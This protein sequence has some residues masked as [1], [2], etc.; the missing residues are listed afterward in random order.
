MS[1]PGTR[2][3]VLVMGMTGFGKS[4]WTKLY[5]QGFSRKVVY[6]PAASFDVK[7]WLEPEEIAERLL[8]DKPPE[9]FDYG[10]VDS[11]PDV[12]G[13]VGDIMFAAGK[14]LYIVEELATV[15]EKGLMRTPQWAKNMCFFGR[16]RECSLV[17]V[18]QRPT[19][20]P[21]DFRS[22]A[23]RVITFCQ[24]EGSDMDWLTDFYGKERMKRLPTLPKFT[25]FDYHYE[26]VVREYS[27][28]PKVE[29]VFGIKLDNRVSIV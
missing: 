3:I 5:H 19:Y 14:N 9:K 29:E 22:Q 4:W 12:V 7:E 25:C 17:L 27:I 18:A 20:I 15:F 1:S 24:H 2:E 8:G 6:D 10:F 21:I 23:N 26:G 11:D 13:A 16:H 28:K